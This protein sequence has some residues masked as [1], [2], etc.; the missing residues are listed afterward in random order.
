MIF[1]FLPLTP[2]VPLPTRRPVERP[3]LRNHC[4][5]LY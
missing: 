3:S 2:P 4:A 5:P 1:V